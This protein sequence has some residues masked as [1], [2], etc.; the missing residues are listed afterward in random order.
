MSIS[1]EF[2]EV[3]TSFWICEEGNGSETSSSS[4]SEEGWSSSSSSLV[5][6]TFGEGGVLSSSLNM[7]VLLHSDWIYFLG[8]TI[9]AVSSSWSWKKKLISYL[10][11]I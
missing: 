6:M 10:C 9:L 7:D 4:F 11:Q 2:G 3:G 5:H 1:G 8:T